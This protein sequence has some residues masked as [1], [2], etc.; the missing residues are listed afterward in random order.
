MGEPR[1][2]LG[3]KWDLANVLRHSDSRPP[4]AARQLAAQHGIAVRRRGQPL[5][6]LPQLGVLTLHSGKKR[7][8]SGPAPA[9]GGTP[10]LYITP[11]DQIV[12]FH[13][14]SPDLA[15]QIDG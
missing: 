4:K 6:D 3:A 9:V 5:L 13:R 7:G 15:Q 10:L 2:L 8:E 1:P 12:H 14:P 11:F